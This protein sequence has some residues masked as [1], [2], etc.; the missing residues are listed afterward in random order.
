MARAADYSHMTSPW[1]HIMSMRIIVTKWRTSDTPFS[2]SAVH[3]HHYVAL[4]NAK[5]ACHGPARYEMEWIY[6]QT[7][8][9]DQ[10]SIELALI[11]E[12]ERKK[13]RSTKLPIF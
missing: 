11:N 7:K 1:Q 10:G 9:S 3:T 5:L 4:H 2:S 12:K 13:E 8:M 6:A